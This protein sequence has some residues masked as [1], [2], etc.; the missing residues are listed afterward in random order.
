MACRTGGR[1]LFLP[2]LKG[3]GDA[4]ISAAFPHGAGIF[5]GS[6]LSDQCV[7][8]LYLL[9]VRQKG[10]KESNGSQHPGTALY[11]RGE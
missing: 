6:V 9:A 1:Y 7:P 10:K 4:L 11:G 5:M 8:G 3:H 2:D